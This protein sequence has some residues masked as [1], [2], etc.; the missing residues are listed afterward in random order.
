MAKFYG[1]IGFAIQSE[2]SPGV[3]EDAIE[4]RPYKG[5]VLQNGRRW[6]GSENINDDFVITNRFSIVSDAFLYS[7]IPAMRYIE[8]MG[9]KFKI[10]SVSME[11]PR[12][13]ISV[14]G[15]YVSGNSSSETSDV[16]GGD[17]WE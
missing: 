6:D 8:Y 15:V 17:S 11:R 5:D 12:V 14:G 4:D 7:H 9:V 1:N 13:D 3:W 10:V 2:T 16:V